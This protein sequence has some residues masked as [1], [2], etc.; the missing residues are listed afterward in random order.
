MEMEKDMVN[1]LIAMAGVI[2]SRM[3]S[4]VGMAIGPL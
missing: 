1:F 3:L 2:E 4:G